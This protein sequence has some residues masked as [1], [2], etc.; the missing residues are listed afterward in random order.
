[1]GRPRPWLATVFALYP[2]LGHVYLRE[3]SRALLWFVLTLGT[4]AFAL[5]TGTARDASITD[6]AS[7]WAASQA[8]AAEASTLGI[9]TVTIVW[10]FSVADAYVIA[11]GAARAKARGASADDGTDEAPSCPACGRPL[12]EDLDFCHWCTTRLDGRAAE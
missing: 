1:M 5:P 11:R 7:V 10:A 3:W 9:V 12:D 2:G 4:S 8:A 6:P